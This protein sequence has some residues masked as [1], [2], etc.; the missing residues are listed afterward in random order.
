MEINEL[1]N[2]IIFQYFDRRAVPFP[3]NEQMV[4]DSG[5]DLKAKLKSIISGNR[6]R[7]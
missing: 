7:R 6:F 2:K 5:E 4:Y 3:T 1:V